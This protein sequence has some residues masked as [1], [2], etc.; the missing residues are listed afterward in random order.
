MSEILN[1]KPKN[2]WKFFYEISNIPRCSKKE[3]KIIEYL[4][5]CAKK[6]NKEYKK[7]HVG[8][9]LIKIEAN[10][11]NKESI[12]LQSHM[13]MVC[14]KNSSCSI[15]FDNDPIKILVNDNIVKAD[16]TTLG[17]DNGIGMAMMLSLL[18]EEKE[19]DHPEL[20]LLFTV[21]EETG[22]TGAMNLSKDFFSS[23]RFLN[24]DSEDFSRFCIGCAGGEDTIITFNY[25]NETLDKNY[26]LINIDIFGLLGGHSGVDINKSRL[27]AIKVLSRILNKLLT[28]NKIYLKNFNGG[29]KR[30]AIPREAN[31]KIFV[32][33]KDIDKIFNLINDEF[34]LIFKENLEF[35]PNLKIKFEKIDSDNFNSLSYIDSFNL[36]SFLHSAYNGVIK[37]NS[38][39][40][41]LVETSTNL[42][43]L[44]QNDN[45]FEINFCS[46]S[47]N[48]DQLT[49]ISSKLNSLAKLLNAKSYQTGRYPGW[50]PN[51]NSIL[52]KDIIQIFKTKFKKEPEIESIHAGLECGFIKK[53]FPDVDFI[54]FGPNIKNPHSPDELVEID[55]VKDFYDLTIEILKTI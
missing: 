9:I 4:E 36:I 39:I 15:D 37:M 27:N 3:E 31:S 49:L 28:N 54:S 42:G 33:N 10:N 6:Y 18:I 1:K 13:D 24:L 32:L 35:E 30:N 44:K 2:L 46:R 11:S 7:D 21:D 40:N 5:N 38:K 25:N 52:L 53:V 14:E 26:S 20:E 43:I 41:T 50:E 47:S 23:K 16:Q 48:E 17:A 8:N 29:N 22:M 55:S 51:V 19:F 12:V 45:L 34:T